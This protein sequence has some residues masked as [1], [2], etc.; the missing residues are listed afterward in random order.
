MTYVKLLSRG[1]DLYDE[2][3]QFWKK[4]IFRFFAV[5]HELRARRAHEGRQ[6][7]WLLVR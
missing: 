5:F 7:L 4:L 6:H 3:F 2:L 1:F